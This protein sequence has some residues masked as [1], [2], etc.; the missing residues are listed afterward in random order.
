MYSVVAH[1]NYK[2]S[3]RS[4]RPQSENS[5]TEIRTADN[6]RKL[7]LYQRIFR[8]VKRQFQ[9]EKGE[10]C[11][12]VWRSLCSDQKMALPVCWNMKYRSRAF[13]NVQ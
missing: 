7:S 12:F 10:F 5:N 8:Y 3:D 6:H 1:Q 2:K 4:P 9:Q 11:I 13:S